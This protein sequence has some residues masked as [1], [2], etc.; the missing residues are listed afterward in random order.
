MSA[1]S[2]KYQNTDE[3]AG[4]KLSGSKTSDIQINN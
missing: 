4:F 2:E 3:K 1:I